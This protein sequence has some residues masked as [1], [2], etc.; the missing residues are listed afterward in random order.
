MG[1]EAGTLVVWICWSIWISRNQLVFQKRSFTLAETLQKA[2]ADARKWVMAQAPS[3]STPPKPL[4]RFE[5]NPRRS[6][7]CS[8][9]TD[10]AWNSTTAEAGFGWIINDLVLTSQH[11][12]TST[13]VSSPP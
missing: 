6:G 2:L 11:A 13:F 4:I 8:V 10:A 1:I 5:P 12:E 3:I 9:F 7:Q